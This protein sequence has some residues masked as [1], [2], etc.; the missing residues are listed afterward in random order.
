MRFGMFA[1]AQHACTSHME[2]ASGPVGFAMPKI[3]G[4]A[5]ITGANCC[6]CPNLS[7]SLLQLAKWGLWKSCMHG[8]QCTHMHMGGVVNF[9]IRPT[10]PV[11]PILKV[12]GVY[13]SVCWGGGWVSAKKPVFQFVM[14]DVGIFYCPSRWCIID[15]CCIDIIPMFGGEFGKSL[16]AFC[17][18]VF[19]LYGRGIAW[20]RG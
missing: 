10:I 17:Y 5:R 2:H 4:V 19:V 16:T 8:T 9:I 15:E 1:H 6:F 18:G 12:W 14:C 11:G 3:G 20:R 13:M 7:L